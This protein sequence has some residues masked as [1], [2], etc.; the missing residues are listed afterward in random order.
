MILSSNRATRFFIAILAPSRR[1]RVLL[2]P[3]CRPVH[4]SDPFHQALNDSEQRIL[5]DKV[6]EITK[7]EFDS[8]QGSK[9]PRMGHSRF[10]G[11]SFDSDI[12]KSL[13]VWR[14]DMTG[15]LH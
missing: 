6:P 9:K 12:M 5:Q 7:W 13:L 2:V 1:R 8:I 14:V 15:V 11:E 10:L 3:K 4:F